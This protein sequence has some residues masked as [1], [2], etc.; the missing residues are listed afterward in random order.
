MKNKV[1]E[2]IVKYIDKHD[3][4]FDYE[5]YEEMPVFYSLPDLECLSQFIK[6]DY[7][8]SFCV[9]MAIM[10]VNQGMLHARSKLSKKDFD[11]YIIYFFVAINK[12]EKGNYVTVNVVF[13]RNAKERLSA[14]DNPIDVKS[15]NVYEYVK[16]SIGIDN[17][18][19]FRFI[20]EYEDEF[21]SFIPKSIVYKFRNTPSI[22]S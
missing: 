15:S 11:N 18:L 7:N 19:C 8:T 2:Q 10:Y 9:N 21:Y 17:F 16:D 3:I 1:F 12:Y 14:F 5:T 6:E 20:D 22:D 13:S 4:L